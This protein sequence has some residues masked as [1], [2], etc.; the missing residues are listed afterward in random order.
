M[1]NLN[2]REFSAP[3]SPTE[4]IDVVTGID[5]EGWDIR[6]IFRVG[7]RVVT[8]NNRLYRVV[9]FTTN[10]TLICTQ[11]GFDI[12]PMVV[13]VELLSSACKLADAPSS[14]PIYSGGLVMFA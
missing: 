3:V 14:K 10:D 1:S 5:A 2:S 4:S 13:Y 12:D 11:S 9:G 7:D 8:P 6:T